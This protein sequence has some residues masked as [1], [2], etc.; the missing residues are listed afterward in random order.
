[1]TSGY[2][3]SLIRDL[4]RGT[5]QLH[6]RV[7]WTFAFKQFFLISVLFLSNIAFKAFLTVQV[8]I[9]KALYNLWSLE[10]SSIIAL[11]ILYIDIYFWTWISTM[12]TFL[13]NGW[14]RRTESGTRF[15]RQT[16]IMNLWFQPENSR[17]EVRDCSP[18]TSWHGQWPSCCKNTSGWRPW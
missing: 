18:K 10:I 13:P 2:S 5:S 12:K 15:T 11:Y 8:N 3:I 4:A 6:L 7:A 14:P 9:Y 17:F 1:M 16:Q